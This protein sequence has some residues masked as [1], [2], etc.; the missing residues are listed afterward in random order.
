MMLKRLLVV[1]SV[2]LIVV[3]AFLVVAPVTGA[4]DTQFYRD[5]AKKQ[6]ATLDDGYRAICILRAGKDDGAKFEDLRALLVKDGIAPDSWPA[7][8]Q[9]ELTKGK[10]ALMICKALDI[11]GGV[12]ARIFGMTE[13][14]ALR[15]LAYIGIMPQK[16]GHFFVSGTELLS[17]LSRAAR[18]KTKEPV[19]PEGE[20]EEGSMSTEPKV[21]APPEP[22]TPGTSENK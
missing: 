1:S 15:E 13:R 21:E 2:T 14:Y 4:S 8:P 3:S 12:I 17:V 20:D 6:A 18:Y 11:K 22:G 16:S 5:L 7:E 9:T 19:E 10:L